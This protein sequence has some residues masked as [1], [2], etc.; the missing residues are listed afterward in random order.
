MSFFISTLLS[1]LEQL[2]QKMGT[3]RV[4]PVFYYQWNPII[5]F[6]ACQFVKKKKSSGKT[7][8]YLQLHFEVESIKQFYIVIYYYKQAI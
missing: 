3:K 7:N 8:P 4:N 5:S 1:I 2:L 6:N